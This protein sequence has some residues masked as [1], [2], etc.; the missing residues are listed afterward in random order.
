VSGP[1]S[2]YASYAERVT[3]PTR[4]SGGPRGTGVGGFPERASGRGVGIVIRGG[5]GRRARRRWACINGAAGI[6]PRVARR[7]LLVFVQGS[8]ERRVERPAA[9]RRF[10]Q[11]AAVSTCAPARRLYEEGRVVNGVDAV[12]VGAFRAAGGGERRSSLYGL[13]GGRTRRHW[14]PA[15][16][17]Q[18]QK[19]R[20]AARRRVEPPGAGV[21]GWLWV[22]MCQIAS[23]SFLAMSIWATLAPRWRPRRR[24]LR[25]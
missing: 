2:P 23:V 4:S 16:G 13:L 10:R 17:A 6:S 11:G 14:R 5:R 25:W 8:G 3:M 18:V 1:S 9:D 7:P 15:P 20:Q 12:R 19:G 22:S 24:L 21:K